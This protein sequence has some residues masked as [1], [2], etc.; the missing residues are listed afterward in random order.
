M[1]WGFNL[2]SVETIVFNNRSASGESYIHKKIKQA[3]AIWIAGGDQW[4]YISYWRNTAIDSLINDAIINR[5][6]VIGGT[7]AGMAIQGGFYFSARH[8]TVTSEEALSN[9]Y[10]IRMTVDSAK[11]LKN[12][13]L[14]NVITDTHYDDPDRSGKA[15][16]LSGEDHD[17]LGN[18]S[19]RNCR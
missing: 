12:Y 13:F 14:R 3:E 11:F 4:D 1:N 15:C 7:S 19:K 6:I 5:N 17:R 16:C 18:R 9:P 8:G 2:N 10:N